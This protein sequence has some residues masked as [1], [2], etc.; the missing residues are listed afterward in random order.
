MHLGHQRASGVDRAQSPLFGHAAALRAKRR[1]PNT[2]AWPLRAL[3]PRSRRTRPPRRGTARRHICCERSRDRRRPAC[4]TTLIASSRLSI[5]MLT[6]AQKPR[7]AA[8]MIRMVC[9][10]VE[11]YHNACPPGRTGDIVLLPGAATTRRSECRMHRD[12][13]PGPLPLHDNRMTSAAFTVDLAA[14]GPDRCAGAY[15]LGRK[16]SLLPATGAHALR[17]FSRRQLRCC[18]VACGRTF[19]CLRLL[20]LGRRPG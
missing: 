5:A 20:P 4:R 2:A 14:Y 1:E 10:A 17:E 6:P 18:R 16:P 11:P 15:A 8:R 3:R 7:G 9:L 12:Y 19:I 13:V